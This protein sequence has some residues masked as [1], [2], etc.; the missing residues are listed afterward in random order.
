M[1]LDICPVFIPFTLPIVVFPSTVPSSTRGDN[2][3]F[4]AVG[5]APLA[6]GEGGQA[7]GV[8]SPPRSG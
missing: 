2:I 8:P 7:V 6:S 4:V 5:A 1:V 3:P